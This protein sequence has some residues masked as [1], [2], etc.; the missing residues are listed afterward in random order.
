M[1]PLA[2]NTALGIAIMSY[3]GQL[4]FGLTADYDALADVETLARG[5]ACRDRGARR[6][7]AEAPECEPDPAAAA[8][9]GRRADPDCRVD[10]DSRTGRLLERVAIGVASLVLSVGAIAVLSG[11]FAGNDRPGSPAAPTGPGTAFKDL[12]DAHLPP[13]PAAAAVQLDPP[14]SG[15]HVPEPVTRDDR[16]ARRQPAADRRCRSAT[17]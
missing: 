12:G 14:T 16:R 2:E 6:P 8:R 7:S 15:A 3:N 4:N 17:S 11:Y 13:G 5:A 9:R 1:V 10:W